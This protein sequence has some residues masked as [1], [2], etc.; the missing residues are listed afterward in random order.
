[1]EG[2]LPA[3]EAP[4]MDSVSMDSLGAVALQTA[5]LEKVAVTASALLCNLARLH[6]VRP[7]L[8]ASEEWLGM[9]RGF[10]SGGGTLGSHDARV[11]RGLG[12]A[13]ATAGLT[14]EPAE[15]YLQALRD[16]LV[17]F[18]RSLPSLL[19]HSVSRFGHD[20]ARV[21]LYR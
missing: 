4:I 2:E 19:D 14:A 6:C 15:G 7:A 1:M 5:G 21:S 8:L 13:L 10:A 18:F 3:D 9:A 12:F 20:C 16:A 11:K 17:R